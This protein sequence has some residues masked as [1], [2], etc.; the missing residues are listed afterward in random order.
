GRGCIFTRDVDDSKWNTLTPEQ[1]VKAMQHASFVEGVVAPK[2]GDFPI[3]Y[4]FKTAR[5]EAGLMEVL[6]VVDDARDGWKEKGMRF[7]YKMV[8]GDKAPNTPAGPVLAFGPANNGLQAA[9]ELIPGDPMKLRFHIRN[10]SDHL[11]A[12]SG[13]HLRTQDDCLIEDLQGQ[14][15]AVR[16]PQGEIKSAIHSGGFRPGQVAVFDSAG[17]T[18][19]PPGAGNET[20]YAAGAGA[21]KYSVRFRL[22]LPGADYPLKEETHNWQG[23]LETAPVA[24][25]I[26][27]ASPA[28][29]DS[30][31]LEQAVNDFNKRYQNEAATAGQPPLN[32]EAVLAAI[33]QAMRDRPKLSVTNQTFAALGRVVETRVLPRNFELE[34]LT[35]YEPDDQATFDVWSVRLRVPGTVIPGGTTC[36]MI[37][38]LLLGTHVIGEEERKVIHA[39]REKERVQ[40]GIV[41]GPETQEYRQEREAAAAM[42][43]RNKA[44]LPK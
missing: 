41:F 38:E 39:W 4:L 33:R 18:F 6:G 9:L 42:D 19:Q 21:G 32:V 2:K 22:H 17:L 12:I 36:I 23:E 37:H 27:G 40:G 15:V 44:A 16:K 30:L 8:R 11:I 34:L 10:V 43:A 20:A 24:V 1:V 35:G 31:S 29:D 26:K 13:M 7:R 3:T 5:G 25:E 14:P 28:A